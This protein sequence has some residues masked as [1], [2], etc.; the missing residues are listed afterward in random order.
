MAQ[1]AVFRDTYNHVK[2]CMASLNEMKSRM[3]HVW[4]TAE[5]K[6]NLLLSAMEYSA[7]LK[8]VNIYTTVH[9]YFITDVI[10]IKDFLIFNFFNFFYFI[11]FSSV[12]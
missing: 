3:D 4:K 10:C 7:Q 12:D 2:D 8:Q 1:K 11:L 9:V 5:S 6:I